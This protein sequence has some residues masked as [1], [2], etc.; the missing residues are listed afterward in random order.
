MIGLVKD[1]SADLQLCNFGEYRG[2][3]LALF[4]LGGAPSCSDNAIVTA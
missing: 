3:S 1:A 4:G 2:Y